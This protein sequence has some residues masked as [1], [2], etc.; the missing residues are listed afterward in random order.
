LALARPIKKFPAMFAAPVKQCFGMQRVV[1][2][3]FNLCIRYEKVSWVM[4]G[5]HR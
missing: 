5:Q 3:Y 2:K 4:A 1:S